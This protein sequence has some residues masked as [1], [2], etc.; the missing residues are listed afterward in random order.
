MP[1]LTENDTRSWQW[2]QTTNTV[3]TDEVL[4][5]PIVSVNN[6]TTTIRRQEGW[7]LIDF[8]FTGCRPCI[9]QMQKISTQESDIDLNFFAEHSITL[10][11]I[12]PLAGSAASIAS[13]GERYQISG[14]LYHAKGLASV[15]GI[16][17]MPRLMLISPDRKSYYDIPRENISER[18]LQIIR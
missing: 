11:M 14:L 18:I 13:F 10:M 17:R 1:F 3:L 5:Y 16:K 4:D 8:W 12:N 6:D 7:L 2:W 15:F 9:E